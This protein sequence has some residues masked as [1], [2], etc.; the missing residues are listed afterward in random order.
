MRI[1]LI[2]INM[3]SKALNFACPLHTY[4]FQQ[5]LLN[6]GIEST[7]IDYKPVYYYNFNLKYPGAYYAE[8]YERQI[9]EGR[10]TL[11]GMRKAR[12]RYMKMAKEREIR[13]E[14][15]Q[16]FID[17]NYIKTDICYDSDLLE[18]LDPNFDCYI[19]VTDVIWK[20]EPGEGFDR[21]FFLG[22]KAMEGK[23]KIAY[24]ASRKLASDYS[25]QKEAEFFYYVNDIEFISVR[26]KSLKQFIESN[27]NKKAEL[28]LDPVLLHDRSFYDAIAVP[29]P[30]TDYILVYY[31]VESA[32]D[33]LR[34]AVDYAR[35][36]NLTI[37]ELSD[38]P[39]PDRLAEFD[40]V[41][42]VFRYD[43]GIEEWLGYIRN[44]KR[45]FT[46]SFHGTC[47]SLIF[48]KSFYVG[49][50]RSD[51]IINLLEET[52]LTARHV[53]DFAEI[54][55][56][57]DLNID[58]SQVNEK[59]RS[60]RE[61]SV[62]FI[63]NSIAA[64]R[65]LE[66]KGQQHSSAQYYDNWKRNLSYPLLYHSGGKPS[67]VDINEFGF[68]DTA[69]QE[70]LPSGSVQF[71]L[72]AKVPNDGTTSLAHCGFHREQKQFC[73]WRLRMRIDK[74]EFWV[75]E[76]GSLILKTEGAYKAAI[77][78]PGTPIPHI[79][80]NRISFVVAE[81]VWESTAYPVHYNSGITS[82]LGKSSFPSTLGGTKVL[83]SGSIEFTPSALVKNNGQEYLA[84]NRFAYKK[85]Q[86]VGWR[87]RFKERGVWY[88][89]LADGTTIPQKSYSKKR[90]GERI[91]LK[92]EEVIPK[93]TGRDVESVVFEAS[94]K[95]SSS[96]MNLYRRRS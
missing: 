14:K 31:V 91:M 19:C 22:S 82:S 69:D 49:K 75:L 10:Q 39:V 7:V 84:R 86:F 34:M 18:V 46:N 78:S 80:V 16:N 35:A 70:S 9:L 12:D 89:V 2:S 87:M 71:R 51:K 94:W 36:H 50:R 76:D 77:F 42:K 68:D 66:D 52:D 67:Q 13:Y 90:D 41:K 24:A 6:N 44:A 95:N 21:G 8:R 93:L 48:E 85:K 11:E 65:D 59:L 4:A 5:F 57:E 61:K 53:A 55:R 54:E 1:G 81:A 73:G 3:Y 96:F 28:V 15:F 30:E 43:I 63:L 62:S 47:F 56:M 27:S 33:T 38:K 92:D 58:Y 64:V 72:S 20:D 79:P 88:W 40:D 60:L 23:R 17:N 29:P 25:P 45:V 26:E 32:E 74:R 83:K 37:V